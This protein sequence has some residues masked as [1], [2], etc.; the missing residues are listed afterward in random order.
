MIKERYYSI[1][2]KASH[3]ERM[4]GD[5]PESANNIVSYLIVFQALH[6]EIVMKEVESSLIYKFLG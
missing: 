5:D 2:F 3:G 1:V 6:V 4:V